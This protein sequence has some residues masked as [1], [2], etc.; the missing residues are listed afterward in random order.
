MSKPLSE[1]ELEELFKTNLPPVHIPADLAMR[2]E[3]RVLAEVAVTFHEDAA[4]EGRRQTRGLRPGWLNVLADWPARLGR[5]ASLTLTGAAVA[6]L[7]LFVLMLPRLLAPQSIES[8]TGQS[9]EELLPPAALPAAT[10]A[11]ITSVQGDVLIQRGSTGLVESLGAGEEDLLG[12]GDIVQANSGTAEIEFFPDQRATLEPFTRIRLVELQ[13][14]GNKTHVVLLQESGATHHTIL[15]SLAADDRY[16]VRTTAMRATVLGTEFSVTVRSV[17]ETAIQTVSGVVYIE[18]DAGRMEV[19]AGQSVVARSGS[20]PFVEVV[21][22][23]ISPTDQL[24][25]SDGA[26]QDE[27]AEQLALLPTPMSDLPKSVP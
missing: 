24:P 10:T 26:T 22:P 19:T 1:Q 15:Q 6:A 12:E 9:V 20:E 13:G 23:A 21:D 8:F 7:L 4:A 18:T 2:L 14:E 27:R 16:E 25:A 3:A 5:G 11:R 17:E